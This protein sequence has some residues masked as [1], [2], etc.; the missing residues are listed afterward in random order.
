MH[1]LFLFLILYPLTIFSLSHD[2]YE[3]AT[4]G[5]DPSS[6]IGGCVSA[7]S[8][9]YFFHKDTLVVRGHEPIRLRSSYI[10]HRGRESGAGW[11]FWP[12]HL[13]A[14]LEI[15]RNFMRVAY[16][17]D[18]PEKM[19]I[20]LI[21]GDA[22]R[23]R[24]K[25]NRE[26]Y[27]FSLVGSPGGLTNCARG[28]IGARM[29]LRNNVVYRDFNDPKQIIVDGADGSKR[30][31]RCKRSLEFD[32]LTSTSEIIT[33]QV[34][35]YLTWE[36]L[37]NGN[38]VYYLYEKIH[39]RILL[40]SIRTSDFLRQHTYAYLYFNYNFPDKKHLFNL[41][42]R[43]SDEQRA[44]YH[45]DPHQK[46]KGVRFWLLK[47][48]ENSE[49]PDETYEYWKGRKSGYY[50]VDRRLPENRLFQVN[51]Y[52]LG[53]NYLP[54]GSVKIKKK[55][56]D[57]FKRVSALLGPIGGDTTLHYAHQIRY[58]PG[59][60]GKSA[61]RTESYDAEGNL[62]EYHY[63]KNFLLRSVSHFQGTQRLFSK[64]IFD[65]HPGDSK[66][67][68]WLREKTLQDESGSP[69]F[70]YRYHYDEKGNVKREEYWGNLTGKNKQ[71]LTECY[72]VER[73]YWPNGLVH[74][75]SYP[76]GQRVENI[77]LGST[78]LLSIRYLY[79]GESI[80]ERHFYFYE[81]SILIKEIIDD[82][83]T[84]SAANLQG[85][86]Q[87]L[88][89]II[90][91]R[92]SKSF[93]GF[94]EVIEEK[95]FD[96]AKNCSVLLRKQIITY[97]SK[98]LVT[99]IDLFDTNE[100]YRYSLEYRYDPQGRLKE[101]KDPLG[102][103]RSIQYDTNNNPIIDKDPNERFIIQNSYDY[104]NRPLSST[105]IVESG[106]ERSVQ[107]SYNFLH[108]KVSETDE[109]GNS[110][111]YKYNPFG[112]PVLTTLPPTPD[113]EG[114][115]RSSTIKKTYNALGCV[116]Q[117]TDPE[118]HTTKY[119]YTSRGKPYRIIHPDGAEE[120]YT[121][122]LSGPVETHTTPEGTRTDYV[123]DYRSR[124]TS[125]TLSK[126]EVILSVETY[127]YNTFHL[128]EKTAPDGVVTTY[129]YDYA[130]RKIK[131]ETQDRAIHFNYDSLGRV[132]KI[133]QGEQVTLKKYDLLDRVL[134]EE[135]R[136]AQGNLYAYILY[137]YDDYSN[138]IAL[139]REVHS[140]EAIEKFEYDPFRRLIRKTDPLGHETTIAYSDH[141]QNQ[142]GQSVI[143]K[144]TTDPKGKKTIETF[145]TLGN[146]S[147]LEKQ[148]A[149]GTTLLEEHFY[150]N[151]N[152]K[153]IRQVSTLYNPDKTF[154]TSWKYDS[155]G[156]LT[157][158][159]EAD[160]KITLYAYNLDGHLKNLTKPDGIV[161][162]YTYD[163]LGR[164]TSIHTS[165]GNCH[166]T[167]QYDSMGYIIHSHDPI[168]DLTSTRLYSHFGELL[169]ERLA[170]G[171][172]LTS[173][174]DSLG[175]KTSLI[176]PDQSSVHYTYD[177]YHL[178][179]VIRLD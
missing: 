33:E 159:S 6:L 46:N 91:P 119:F 80:V 104:S 103:R 7:I 149:E 150:T 62:T 131:E 48:I 18:M 132:E 90:T 54:I 156:R 179:A 23:K 121:Y 105:K 134:E 94:P 74:F 161:I 57:R 34:P 172:Q 109:Q 92:R 51:Y 76:S 39:G 85:V 129:S 86:S 42:L 154:T 20:H 174:Y 177:P 69:L 162:T 147:H 59:R 22:P 143:Q 36:K 141:F 15:H 127:K 79:D 140:G 2:P 169:Q 56:D 128:L 106:E 77:Y 37:P 5:G 28:E 155:R 114:T 27:Y 113:E 13:V 130:G 107:N 139:T 163:G 110:I 72:F 67:P 71:E 8:G 83:E 168:T 35:F 12:N 61:G 75:E 43:G 133:T 16:V 152:G 117:E 124:I 21:Y 165:D 60:Y 118:G 164:Q 153:K 112:H 111:H 24:K 9:D 17:L 73:V 160:Q 122:T 167:L 136:N 65:W 102:R 88:I 58:Y 158:L 116:T 31:Y 4:L 41:S 81:G 151:L 98:G 53:Q 29:N 55:S 97:N 125:R 144:T 100:E 44:R 115:L 93:Y 82:G 50:L 99:K 87:R 10:S 19:G 78:D 146:L 148:N 66:K 64:E 178:T 45:F 89:K 108:Q 70:S 49:R 40:S 32:K 157:E 3:L 95:Y 173:T 142:H 47:K 135:E 175:R 26:H 137:T 11:N 68:N 138:K 101:Q 166:Y 120:S 84:K 170:N 30:C 52:T 38:M 14:T 171:Y 145:D 123:Y 96:L 126:N 25:G 176:F 63:D 1:R